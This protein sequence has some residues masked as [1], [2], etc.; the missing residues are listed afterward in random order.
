M[1]WQRAAAQNGCAERLRSVP[2]REN[3]VDAALVANATI[4]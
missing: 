2:N 4:L 3:V 1:S